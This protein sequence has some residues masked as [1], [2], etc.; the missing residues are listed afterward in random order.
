MYRTVPRNT[1]GLMESTTS[2][3]VKIH[4][5]HQ[6]EIARPCKILRHG[7]ENIIK[8]PTTKFNENPTYLSDIKIHVFFMT[9]F[10]RFAQKIKFANPNGFLKDLPSQSVFAK[11]PLIY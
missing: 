11:K 7:I 6:M 8:K 4:V 9:F 5:R 3:Q 10:S 1:S 2:Y